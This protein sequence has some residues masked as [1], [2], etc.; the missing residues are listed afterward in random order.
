[1][2]AGIEE[3]GACQLMAVVAR[4]GQTAMHSAW[5]DS[6]RCQMLPLSSYHHSQISTSSHSVQIHDRPPPPPLPSPPPCALTTTLT[7]CSMWSLWM[8]TIPSLRARDCLQVEKD[9][10]N[11][12]FLAVP[13]LNVALPFV[14]K[15]F[16][17]IY[18]ADCVLMVAVYASKGLLPGMSPGA[19]EE[20]SSS[21]RSE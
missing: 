10:L 3:V 11:L 7:A 17:F 2:H 21:S 1:M 15:N 6:W 4:H 8:F 19:A 12:L 5:V 14:W 9:A 13:L 16:G 20:G 18:S